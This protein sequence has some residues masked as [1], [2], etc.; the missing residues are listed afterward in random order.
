MK[1]RRWPNRGPQH[2]ST[3]QPQ[4]GAGASQ[5]QLG[6]GAQQ[7]PRWKIPAWALEQKLETATKTAVR[8]TRRMDTSPKTEF[9]KN[10]RTDGLWPREASLLKCTLFAG[11]PRF[12]QH[13]S[14]SERVLKWVRHRVSAFLGPQCYLT[15]LFYLIGLFSLSELNGFA[16]KACQISLPQ[17]RGQ[18]PWFPSRSFSIAIGVSPHCFALVAHLGGLAFVGPLEKVDLP[19]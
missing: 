9:L 13:R 16:G 8:M 11:T 17:Q 12:A 19:R 14:I 10:A 7:S 3:S 2:G 4:L 6:A 5:P 18:S 1:P 15:A